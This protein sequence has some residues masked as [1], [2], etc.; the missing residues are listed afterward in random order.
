MVLLALSLSLL[1][2][3]QEKKIVIIVPSG[4]IIAT[5]IKIIIDGVSDPTSHNLWPF[6]I[7][8][9]A[10]IGFASAFIGAGIGFMTKSFL[11]L[12]K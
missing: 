7:I 4:L 12:G 10:V 11:K 6:E 1:T 2:K 9:L 8:L 3:G 5:I